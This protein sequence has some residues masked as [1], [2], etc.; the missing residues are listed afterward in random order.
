MTTAIT[1]TTTNLAPQEWIAERD[2]LLGISANLSG[3]TNDWEFQAATEM[4]ARLSE[5][6][7]TLEQERKAITGKFDAAKKEI[8]AQERD[9]VGVIE[10]EYNRLRQAAGDYATAKAAEREAA[11]RARREAIAEREMIQQTAQESFCDAVLPPPTAPAPFVPDKL[12]TAPG[13]KQVIRYEIL[14]PAQLDRKFLSP[15]EAK[16]R[17]FVQFA[18]L[19]GIKAEDIKEPGLRV[20]QKVSI[21]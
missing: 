5:M 13:R 21:N 17:S 1:I 15:D 8:M 18:K 11:E 7:K 16:I 4:V 9:L 12:K 6:R 10:S 2:N 14:D 3:V 19:Q 20:V